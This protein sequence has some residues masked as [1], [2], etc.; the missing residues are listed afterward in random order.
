[1]RW[2]WLG[3]SLQRAALGSIST[4]KA[5]A[6]SVWSL[7]SLY[8]WMFCPPPCATTTCTI[9]R[10]LNRRP[11]NQRCTAHIKVY[12]SQPCGP[13]KR[14][15]ATFRFHPALPEI[16]VFSPS[17][18]PSRK[19][20]T[21]HTQGIGLCPHAWSTTLLSAGKIASFVSKV[22]R[23]RSSYP[24]KGHRPTL[25]Q[26]ARTRSPPP[27]PKRQGEPCHLSSLISARSCASASSSKVPSQVTINI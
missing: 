11:A 20:C 4:R 7:T 12:I 3:P 13:M 5:A 23:T 1:L 19:R 9:A 18:P 21:A 10:P 2:R 26:T 27:D 6:H 15:Q 25:R 16:S 14:S 17:L 24:Q 8:A 22:A